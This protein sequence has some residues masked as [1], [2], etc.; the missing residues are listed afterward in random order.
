MTPVG[1]TKGFLAYPSSAP[2]LGESLKEAANEL[3]ASLP[4]N[5]RAWEECS[6]GGKFVMGEICREI[7][8]ASLFCADLTGLNANVMFELG[9]AIAGDKR[10][11]LVLDPTI[12]GFDQEFKQLKLLT[13]IGYAKCL[14]SQDITRC[15]YKDSPYSDL[16]ATIFRQ[17]IEPILSPSKAAKFLLYLKSRHDTEASNRLSNEIQ[18]ASIPQIVDDPRESAVQ[19][20]SWYGEKVYCAAGIVCH[21]TSLTREGARLHN[22]RHAL[23]CGLAYGWRKPLIMLA[24]SEYFAPVDYRDLLCNYSTARE[25][26]ALLNPWLSGVEK[27]QKEAAGAANVA[28]AIE[29]ATELKD[30]QLQIGEWL[31]E[32]ESGQLED[33]FVE[34]TAYQEAL[35]GR[36]MIFVGRKGTGKTAN[37]L[38]LASKLGEDRANLVC[39]IRP[40]AYEIQSLVKL[41]N[42]YR[43][44][45]TKGYAIEGL[46]KYLVFTEIAS[47]AARE[48]EGRQLWEPR[49]DEEKALLQLISEEQTSI[50]GDFSVR[51]ERCV[52]G[53]FGVRESGS[54]EQYRKG[55]SEALH[56]GSL[57]RI[58]AVLGD[59][60][61][62]KHR[63]A[64]LVDN[65]DRAWTRH[66]DITQLSEFLLGLL[67][68]GRDVSNDFRRGGSRKSPVNVSLAVFLRSD[69]FS[70][71][72]AAAREPDKL[73]Y[74]RLT[75]DDPEL[76]RR[77]I[78]ERFVA[79][80][81]HRL[82]GS[83]MWDRYFCATVDGRPTR[84]YM[85]DLILPRPRDVVYLTKAAVSLAVNRRHSRV[86]ENDVLDGERQYSQY[87]VDSILV[88]N[89]I[90]LPELEAVLI[91]FA[92]STPI[93]SEPEALRYIAKVGIP[94]PRRQHVIEHLVSLTFLGIETQAG[95]FAF[96]DDPRESRRNR[97]LSDKVLVQDGK[98]RRYEINPAFCSYLGIPRSS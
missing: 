18:Q 80:H 88:E 75:W 62:K 85:T 28:A 74:T 20:L 3:N 72:A 40:P 87:A 6:V 5:L 7:D 49:S 57:R 81:G 97:A 84:Q 31:A 45:D 67:V 12:Q 61:G 66:A 71:V 41:F 39:V 14:N 29:L 69:I 92:G 60:L 56:E 11:W 73:V 38:R 52:N 2:S 44:R 46:W 22:A 33:Y 86:E 76:L 64:I 13:T 36:Q 51:L 93:V 58:R 90:T 19:P 70:S 91:E 50:T 48:I 95:R 55:I 35:E 26:V 83:E 78:E 25:A 77:I 96:S 65:L 16:E 43:E 89:G 27:Q 42:S 9:Y 17:A 4:V 98:P 68:V 23:V 15:F 79:A 63:V 94:E 54:V 47:A 37:L 24:E 21:F 53:L 30:F 1:L 59:A 10:I 8:E 32:N 34:T 82:P